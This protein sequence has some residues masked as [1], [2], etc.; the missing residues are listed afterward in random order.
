METQVKPKYRNLLYLLGAAILGFFMPLIGV[1][2]LLVLEFS[3][4]SDYF[5]L[6]KDERAMTRIALVIIA[7]YFVINFFYGVNSLNDGSSEE[8][9]S[10]LLK[11]IFIK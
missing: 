6:T 1:G 11:L 5:K 7:V 3:G 10:S 9:L 8:S 2:A 4:Q